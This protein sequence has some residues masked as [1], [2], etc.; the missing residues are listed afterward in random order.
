MV[1]FMRAMNH[2]LGTRVSEDEVTWKR[3]ES[4]R[5]MEPFRE[6]VKPQHGPERFVS[7]LFAEL[8]ETNDCSGEYVARRR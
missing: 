8:E 3:E 7:P 5:V 2:L 1:T 6:Y 4:E